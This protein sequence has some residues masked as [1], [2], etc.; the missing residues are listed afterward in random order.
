MKKI[1]LYIF[2]FAVLLCIDGG[3]AKAKEADDINPGFVKLIG[4]D[5]EAAAEGVTVQAQTSKDIVIFRFD[6][7]TWGKGMIRLSDA[8]GKI[9]LEKEIKDWDVRINLQDAMP[10]FYSITVE[11]EHLL[12]VVE[13]RKE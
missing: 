10:G 4:I 5:A 13:I 7:K 9:L 2:L 8:R 1:N 11:K 3:M 12:E 6:L